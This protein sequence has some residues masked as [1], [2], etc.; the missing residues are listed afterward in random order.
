M[1]APWALALVPCL[2]AA[3]QQQHP[4]SEQEPPPPARDT[5]FTLTLNKVIGQPGKEA[6][7]PV[8]FARKPGAPNVTKLRVRVV[9]PGSVLKFNRAEDAYLSRRVKLQVQGK[10]DKGTGAESVLEL[11][12]DLPDPQGSNFPSGQIATVF[13][14]V[15]AGAADQIVP[16]KPQAWIDGAEILPDSP[17]AQIEPGEVRVS[18]NP[19]FVGCFFFTH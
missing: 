9:Y 6:S 14:D 3:G 13:F 10:E 17:A 1:L 11:S 18:Q 12:F 19:V 2:G 5:T 4:P 8:L 15:A 7:L 16:L